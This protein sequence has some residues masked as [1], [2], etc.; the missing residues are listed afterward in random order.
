MLFILIIKVT[1]LHHK[2]TSPLEELEIDM[3]EDF[4]VSDSLH[5]IDLGIMKRYGISNNYFF[6]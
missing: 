5:L 4:P 1:E 3:V 6:L 2:C